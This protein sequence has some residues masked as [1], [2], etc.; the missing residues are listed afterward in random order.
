MDDTL[1][2]IRQIIENAAKDAD[3][4]HREY[5][6]A[7]ERFSAILSRVVTEA[8]SYG[9]AKAVVNVFENTYQEADE[10]GTPGHPGFHICAFGGPEAIDCKSVLSYLRAMGQEGM[11]ETLPDYLRG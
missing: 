6:S 4:A 8:M 1:N 2:Q 9:F 11:V 3:A 10:H 5:K 7:G